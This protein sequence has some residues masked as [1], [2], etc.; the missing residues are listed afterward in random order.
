MRQQAL[1]MSIGLLVLASLALPIA[2][3][4]CEARNTY[5]ETFVCQYVL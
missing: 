3:Q 2:G 4:N 1:V 5:C